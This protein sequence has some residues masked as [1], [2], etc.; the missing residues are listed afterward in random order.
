MGD[1]SFSNLL[2][3]EFTQQPD[4]TPLNVPPMN[5]VQPTFME[6]ASSWLGQPQNQLM[7]ANIGRG[8]SQ[9]RIIG[10]KVV[11]GVGETLGAAIAPG[12]AGQ[13]AQQV[14]QQTAGAVGAPTQAGQVSQGTP[15]KYAEQKKASDVLMQNDGVRFGDLPSEYLSSPHVS[16]VSV[17]TKP[18]GTK[19]YSIKSPGYKDYQMDPEQRAISMQLGSDYD[20]GLG[21]SPFVPRSGAVGGQT[22][23]VQVP[24]QFLVHYQNAAK[25]YGVP[26]NLLIAVGKNE[27]VGFNPSAVSKRG[28]IGLQ[29]IMPNTGRQMG[30]DPK[31][32]VNPAVNID[33]SAKYIRHLADAY[34]IDL[35]NPAQV[36]MAYNGGPNGMQ[37]ADQD[38]VQRV[39]RDAGGGI[40]FSSSATPTAQP[41]IRPVA[42]QIPGADVR[43][44]QPPNFSNVAPLYGLTP[45]QATAAQREG[46]QMARA[47]STIA[48]EQAQAE[49]VGVESQ[50]KRLGL[51]THT[52]VEVDGVITTGKEALDFQA[53][54]AEIEA[55]KEYY[56][57][58]AESASSL[59]E[60]RQA[61]IEQRKALQEENAIKVAERKAKLDWVKSHWNEKFPGLDQTYGELYS[62]GNLDAAMAEQRQIRLLQ[63]QQEKNIANN[64]MKRK[65]EF[66]KMRAN[67][68]MAQQLKAEA[69]KGKFKTVDDY[70]N[71]QMAADFGSDWK[72][73]LGNGAQ[74]EAAPTEKKRLIYRNGKWE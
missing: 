18:D 21:Q 72:R 32:L 74:G 51:P 44:Y 11:P 28:A 49:N 64:V 16:G 45:E 13:V 57:T 58:Q 55:R 22:S 31:Q 47:P 71:A 40:Q 52:P 48:L 69:M 12:L 33:T 4:M 42:M 14:G 63:A 67:P 9:P 2:G 38:Y 41:S 5:P 29:Q 73:Y 54:M 61:M 6:R 19:S 68:F 59:A 7:L 8:L 10:G 25:K 70:I 27:T 62:T 66:D 37:N 15:G 24:T 26:L 43:P 56:A 60:Y 20:S 36:A 39:A 23:G 65:A 46:V 34:G 53:K 30:V 17:T 35:N 3:G 50:V 1:W